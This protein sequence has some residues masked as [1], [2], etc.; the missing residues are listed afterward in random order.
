V[1][2]INNMCKL[3]FFFLSFFLSFFLPMFVAFNFTSQNFVELNW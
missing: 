3:F 2:L 1:C